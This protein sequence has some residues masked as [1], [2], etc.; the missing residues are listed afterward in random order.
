MSSAVEPAKRVWTEADL[1][2]LPDDGYTHEVVDGEMVMSPK[3][4]FYHGDICS[5][6]LSVMRL[7]VKQNRLGAVLDSSTG[8]WMVNGNCRAPDISFVCRARLKAL[9]FKRKTRSFFPGG[10]D[11]AV[12]ILSLHNKRSEIE[13]RLK[14]FFSSGTRLAWVIDPERQ[15]AEV[16]RGILDRKLVGSSGFLDGEDLLPGFR[17]PLANL[18]GEWEWD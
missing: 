14:D 15:D 3:N 2:A 13:G 1:K 5:E 17:F 16:C 12:E 8:F 4:D 10:P 9:G 11:L 6:L 7:F 18:F